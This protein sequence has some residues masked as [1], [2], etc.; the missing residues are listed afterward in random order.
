MREELI[1]YRICGIVFLAI[2]MA[3]AVM[4]F[5]MVYWNRTFIHHQ[6]TTIAMAAYTFTAFT[7]A[8]INLVKYR[9]YN[10]PVFS[11]SKAISLTSACVSM[12]TLES[13]MLSTFG[14]GNMDDITRKTFLGL[15][16]GV[17]S[18]FIIVMAVYMIVHSNKKTKSVKENKGVLT[19]GKQRKIIQLHLFF[20]RT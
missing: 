10:S 20:Q 16:G 5:F 1:K 13:T 4:I 2:N 7:V 14:N 11:A 17:I 18:A 9:Q 12:L 6:I 15:S 19:N 3:L 8:I